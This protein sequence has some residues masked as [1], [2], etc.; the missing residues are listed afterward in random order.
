MKNILHLTLLTGLLLVVTLAHADTKLASWSEKPLNNLNLGF[1]SLTITDWGGV[2]SN[3]SG[4]SSQSLKITNT[5]EL[6]FSGKKLDVTAECSLVA[7]SNVTVCIDMIT[8]KISGGSSSTMSCHITGSTSINIPQ[9]L[10]AKTC[11]T[12]NVTGG[13][14]STPSGTLKG[15]MNV[16]VAGQTVLNETIF[17]TNF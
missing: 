13:V 9:P 15:S 6:N 11:M 5:S 10:E 14:G 4:Y 1:A 7:A 8:L 16:K 17:K 12:A 3:A 2:Y